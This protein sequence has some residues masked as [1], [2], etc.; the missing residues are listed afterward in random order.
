[1]ADQSGMEL[2]PLNQNENDYNEPAKISDDGSS[3][4]QWLIP[5]PNIDALDEN[6]D[7]GA[8]GNG[9]KG[10]RRPRMEL[11]QVCIFIVHNSNGSYLQY[12]RN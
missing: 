5:Y 11:I 10:K 8:R 3:H 1:M 12:T 6:I 9:A 7:S 4:N 2:L